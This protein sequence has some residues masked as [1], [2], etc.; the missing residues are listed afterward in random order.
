MKQV[1]NS[2][3]VSTGLAIF[4][5]LFGA[6]N[7]MYPLMVGMISGN[8]NIF[9]MAGFLIT[10]VLLPVAGLLAMILFDGNYNTFFKRLGNIPGEII[11]FLC[12]LIIGPLIAIPRIA[13]VSHVMIAPFIP[14]SL[15]QGINPLS[16]FMFAL[17]FFGVTFLFT[18]RE[19]KIID[20]L[21][22]FISPALL[23]SL[24]LIIIKGIFS[25]QQ[26]LTTMHTPW[27][28]FKTNLI[29]G[30]G[31]LDLLGTIFF[32]SVVLHILKNTAGQEVASNVKRRVMLGLKAG[33]LGTSL[34]GI[35]YIGMSYLGVFHGYGLEIDNQELFRLIAFRV[36]G[37]YGAALIGTAVLMA[38]LSTS[39]ALSAVI[40]EYLQLTIFR[41]KIS[42]VSTLVI[43][44]VA[45]L[46]LSTLGLG[47][48]LALTGGPITYVGYPVIITI[49]FCNIAY[50][51]FGFKPIKLPALLTFIGAFISY[52]W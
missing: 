47:Q 43:T 28:A 1:L 30:Y 52:Y 49:V 9:G 50:K 10:T 13:T 7:L 38:C 48:V 8:H 22:H 19:N 35:I 2:T 41:N 6:G 39:I 4:S 11:I 20:L 12:M 16:S 14:I 46:P 33:L 44:L 18:Y 23:I 34:L 29:L 27:T 24:T 31:T 42:F 40:A 17:I 37:N 45:C 36:I 51:L 26:A 32:S 5:M 25:A 15:L 21:G 3:V